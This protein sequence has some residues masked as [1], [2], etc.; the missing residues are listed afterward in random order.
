MVK[1]RTDNDPLNAV[2]G[3]R[4]YKVDARRGDLDIALLVDVEVSGL[5]NLSCIMC[6][7]QKDGGRRMANMEPE[8]FYK[9][10]DQCAQFGVRLMRFSGYGEVLMNKHFPEFLRY[11]KSKGL[12]TH[13]TTNGHLLTEDLCRR[14]VDAPLDKIKIS[15]QGTDEAEY[16][17]M[18]NTDKYW[19]LVDKVRM[20]RRVRDEAGASLPIIQVAT[21]V[22]D[23][24]Q[25]Q[26]DSFYDFWRPVADAVYHLPTVTW[27]LDGTDFAKENAERAKRAKLL[28]TMC[29][30]PMTK[31][32]IWNNGVV[33]GCCGDHFHQL[34]LGDLRDKNLKEIWD[35]EP[36]R[37]IRAL[38][39]KKTPATF[40]EEDRRRYP[41]CAQ[42]M[43][44][45]I[46]R[47]E[48]IE[49]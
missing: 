13:L 20:L 26:I 24:T 33:S 38:L 15:F 2:Y 47:S 29:I 28:D 41:L 5:C 21:T 44:M 34:V 31:M 49:D 22:L 18:R 35:D 19:E 40:S 4:E 23:E 48:H 9:V 46:L 6:T 3:S 37:E 32:S 8:L 43:S 10:A 17:R 1:I 14:L 11:A 36:A 27:R 42:C 16:N 12:L 39:R 7:R 30:E 45:N 25:E